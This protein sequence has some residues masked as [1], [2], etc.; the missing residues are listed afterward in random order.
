[1]PEQAVG[2]GRQQGLAYVCRDFACQLP[3]DDP[4]ALA[5]QLAP[6]ALG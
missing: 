1:M 6:T 2:A 5:A 3:V 4:E